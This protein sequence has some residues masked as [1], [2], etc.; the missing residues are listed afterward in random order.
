MAR[1]TRQRGDDGLHFWPTG[2]Y[3]APE[4]DPDDPAADIVK[5]FLSGLA[6]TAATHGGL[7]LLCLGAG[8]FATISNQGPSLIAML[9]SAMIVLP[10]AL[11]A[12]ARLAYNVSVTNRTSG[13]ALGA[14]AMSLTLVIA[15]MIM[16]WPAGG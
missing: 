6:V 5:G 1:L 11:L 16:I 10:L 7:V 8:L 14:T 2:Y 4:D 13:M 15:V 9:R 12:Q 3:E